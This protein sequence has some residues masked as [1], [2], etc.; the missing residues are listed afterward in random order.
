MT[1][2]SRG[3]FVGELAMF[4]SRG[5]VLL[6]VV[7]LAESRPA[8]PSAWLQTSGNRAW[9]ARQG[10]PAQAAND[11]EGLADNRPG[12]PGA[13]PQPEARRASGSG[14]A[15]PH[16]HR[17]GNGRWVRVCRDELSVPDQDRQKDHRSALVWSLGL[18]QFSPR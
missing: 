14:M 16:A 5:R 1:V 13:V 7:V 10:D 9:R 15:W 17:H 3:M 11:G 18:D 12:W 2:G 6:R 4:M 8:C